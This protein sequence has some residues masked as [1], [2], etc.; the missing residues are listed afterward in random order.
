MQSNSQSASAEAEVA[1]SSS[2]DDID[3]D[4]T[5]SDSDQSVKAANPSEDSANSNPPVV[6]QLDPKTIEQKEPNRLSQA[7]DS[8]EFQDLID[9]V[10][11]A[12][13][14][15][16]HREPWNKGKLV[17]QKAP[18]KLK[19][20]WALRVRLQMEG[21]RQ[22][23]IACPSRRPWLHPVRLCDGISCEPVSRWSTLRASL[24]PT[25]DEG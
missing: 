11:N 3:L 8:P 23:E 17:G 2:E 4:L 10:L 9:S 1:P 5:A 13:G 16:V 15:P 12:R 24:K 21:R 18:F 25:P 7:F 14:N 20:I 6:L 19:D 22:L